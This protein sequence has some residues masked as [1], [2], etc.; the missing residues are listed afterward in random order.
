M[1]QNYLTIALR[2]LWKSR[3][4]SGIN[5]FGLALGLAAAVLLLLWVQDERSYDGFH[6]HADRVYRQAST[7][8]QG[9]Q[10]QTWTGV[11]AATMAFARREVPEIERA[12]LLASN[13][14]VTLFSYGG[15][16]FIEKDNAVYVE[17]SFFQ[18]FSFSFLRGNA[19]KPFANGR[20]LVIT[21]TMAKKYF[22]PGW[23]RTDPIGKVI[24]TDKKEDYQVSGVIRDVPANSHFAP[25]RFFFTMDIYA[26]NFTRNGGNGD[27]KTIDVDWGNYFY[28]GYWLLKPNTSPEAVA[29]KLT[30]IHHRN[31][32]E[33]AAMTY[34]LQALADMH[35]YNADGSGEGRI[36]TVR[37]F[38]VVALVILLIACINYVNLSTARATKRAKEVGIRK[39]AGAGQGQLFGQFLGE[40]LLVFA[41]AFAGAMALIAVF[42]P[43]YNDLSGKTMTLNLLDPTTLTVLGLAM[44]ATVLVAG[45]YP[46]LLLSSFQP[47]T[48]MKG[49]LALGGGNVS[50]RKVLVVTQFS[51]SIALIVGT[52]VISDQLA[53][54]RRKDLGY[55][56][57]NIFSFGMRGEM[58]GRFE[59]IRTEL[60][61][62]TGVLG[63]AAAGGDIINHGSSTGDTDWDGKAP[64]RQFIISPMAVDQD[65][66]S[67][68]GLQLTA[69]RGFTGAKVD[70]ISYILNETAVAQTG[71]RNPIGKRF[72]LHETNGRIIGVVKD[73]HLQSVHEK[74]A[75]TILYYNPQHCYR[76]YV[77]T[78]GRNAAEAIAATD[79]VWKQSN[80]DYPFEYAF[81]D[82]RFNRLYRDDQRTGQLFNYFAAI[83][84]LISCLGLFG[85]ATFTAEQRTKEIGIRKVLGASVRNIVAMLSKEF[86]ALVVVAVVIA[87]PLAGWAM[88]AWLE[89]YAYRVALGWPAFAL[90]GLSA[91]AIA[92]L[93]V[94][95]QAIRAAVANPVQ[96]LRNE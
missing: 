82:E 33:S 20:S 84:I 71:I 70:S 52:L 22:G 7:F 69:G 17:G 55:D 32:K 54:V 47:L 80:P 64:S 37:I 27:W 85:L 5:V 93:T 40:S 2:S 11:P 89:N 34:S 8:S 83:A 53:Y 57:E 76:V 68:L 45:V 72:K 18:L 28:E 3:V 95:Y 81:L 16:N 96:S 14:D 38:T 78:T 10:Q 30:D 42:L 56:K 61:K 51:L 41:L 67:L 31:Q 50:F 44:G 23:E 21:E 75:P 87:F 29:R 1:L 26:A 15:K 60:T 13:Y 49:K 43:T 91:L 48:V 59:S 94:S 79:K 58:N 39:I 92:L 12:A 62:Q 6:A 25:I 35:L 63:V 90:A 4:Y 19:K 88:R 73:F 77:K 36:Q 9:G 24:R 65:F 66:L 86:V 46:A 74:I